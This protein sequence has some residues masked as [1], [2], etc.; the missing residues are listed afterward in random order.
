MDRREA[1][2]AKTL[3]QQARFS[4]GMPR[5]GCARIAPGPGI[6]NAGNLSYKSG[7]LQI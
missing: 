3:G 7:L 2:G 4:P 1:N 6:D 5:A